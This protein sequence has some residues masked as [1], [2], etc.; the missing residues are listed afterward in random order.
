VS[1]FRRFH[2][3]IEAVGQ[4]DS[5]GDSVFLRLMELLE[6]LTVKMTCRCMDIIVELSDY[7]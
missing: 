7:L 4:G 1:S 5:L 3:D 2:L 6:G